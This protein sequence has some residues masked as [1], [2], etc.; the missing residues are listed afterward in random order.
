MK[1][2]KWILRHFKI[3]KESNNKII[4]N[5]KY[6]LKVSL[7]FLHLLQKLDSLQ[8][9]IKLIMVTIKELLLIMITNIIQEL[10]FITKES[11]NKKI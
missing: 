4:N 8:S 3:I 1:I 2:I 5:I 7:L 10:D 9:L 6:N 11:N